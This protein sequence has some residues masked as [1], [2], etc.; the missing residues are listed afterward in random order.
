MLTGV[1]SP[2]LA[3][4]TLYDN[5]SA[6]DLDPSKWYG[7]QYTSGPGA[8]L[9]LVRQVQ[10]GT[11]LLSHRVAGSPAFDFGTHESDNVVSLRNDAGTGD[12]R[13]SAI[14]F[15]VNVSS[16]VATSC[17]TS[18]TRSFAVARAIY[19]AFFDGRGD[20]RVYLE[21]RRDSA[22]TDPPDMLRV[23][24]YLWHDVDGMLPGSLDL[25]PLSTTTTATLR[26][27]WDQVGHKVDFQMNQN[28]A[29][30]IPYTRDD[31]QLPRSPF[32]NLAATGF[33]ANCMAGRQFA[34]ITASFANV[35]V[36]P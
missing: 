10:S 17:P 7:W 30:S 4:T 16:F 9:E 27:S 6:P 3:Q 19:G 31:S 24:G 25:G 34:A 21:V 26:A 35:F 32:G 23:V 18:G 33:A 13:L 22:S 15:D 2:A 11:L 1:P 14:Q 5:F 8:P 12:R 36:D 29:E 28:P 20:V